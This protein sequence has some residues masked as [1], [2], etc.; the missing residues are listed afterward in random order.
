MRKMPQ[1]RRLINSSFFVFMIWTR[2]GLV[3]HDGRDES[4]ILSARVDERLV[5]LR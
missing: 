3:N 1:F 4:L 5:H 2:Q